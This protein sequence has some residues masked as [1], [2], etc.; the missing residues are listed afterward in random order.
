[1][2]FLLTHRSLDS[3]YSN[4]QNKNVQI[5]NLSSLVG[6]PPWPLSPTLLIVSIRPVPVQSPRKNNLLF[7]ND[8]PHGFWGTYLPSA[9]SVPQTPPK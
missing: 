3:Q 4:F 2:F 1:M 8:G 7:A 5:L 9:R 6:M